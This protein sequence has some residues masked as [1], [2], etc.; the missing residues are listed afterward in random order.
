MI[1]ADMREIKEKGNACARGLPASGGVS[2]NVAAGLTSPAG[3]LVPAFSSLLST[4]YPL[5]DAI[6]AACPSPKSIVHYMKPNLSQ[7]SQRFLRGAGS[8]SMFMIHNSGFRIPVFI[9]YPFAF[10][11]NPFCDFP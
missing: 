5:P 4:L 6:G 10:R 1:A 7:L 3:G 9:L 2:R 8:I 11:L